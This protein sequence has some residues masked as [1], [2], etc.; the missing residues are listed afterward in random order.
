VTAK[1]TSHRSASQEPEEQKPCFRL[2]VH[3]RHQEVMT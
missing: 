2:S 1:P 3:F